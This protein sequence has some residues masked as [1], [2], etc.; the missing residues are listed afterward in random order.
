MSYDF[1][2]L[3]KAKK[4]DSR[5]S[6]VFEICQVKILGF[7]AYFNHFFSYIH[8]FTK[9]EWKAYIKH[10]INLEVLQDMFITGAYGT[11][12]CTIRWYRQLN[13]EPMMFC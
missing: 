8:I 10:V 2:P 11:G 9:R 6:N 12:R 3:Y 7:K 13:Q 1:Q 5:S 4:K